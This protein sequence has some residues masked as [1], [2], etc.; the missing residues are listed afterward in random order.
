MYLERQGGGGLA[1]GYVGFWA[2]VRTLAFP[3]RRGN[4]GE[5]EQGE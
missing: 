3:I 5:F 4:I 1:L 2:L